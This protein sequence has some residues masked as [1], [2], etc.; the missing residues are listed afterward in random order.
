MPV[1]TR[2]SATPYNV[3]LKGALT[4][5]S[6]H[7]L[8]KLAHVLIRA[9]LSDGAVG[10]AEATPRPSIYGETQASILHIIEAHLAP[11]LVGETINSFEAASALAARAA[12]I[13]S[14]NTAKGALDMAL[15]QALAHSRGESLAT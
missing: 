6:G 11:M 12:N 3:P 2:I 9:E 8:R 4:W 10:F 15:H 1:I 14:N 7:E 13:K 5:G